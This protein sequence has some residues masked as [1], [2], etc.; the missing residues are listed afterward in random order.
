M[1]AEYPEGRARAAIVFVMGVL[2]PP[3]GARRSSDD[4]HEGCEGVEKGEPS[5]MERFKRLRGL[6]LDIAKKLTWLP[7]L[8]ARLALGYVFIHSGLYK[9]GHLDQITGFFTSL[10]LPAPAFQARFVA[11]TELV[12]GAL[13]LLGAGTRVASLPLAVT[14]V[15]ALVT[16]KK[17][18][19][20]ELHELLLSGEFLNV[21]LLVWLMIAGAGAVSVDRV[22]ARRLE[23]GEAKL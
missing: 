19:I 10:H 12:C 8:L 22:I 21:V 14:M 4:A 16:A 1:W 2:Y 20:H 15:V 17:D 6:V 18:E 23:E 5:Y 3:R 11:G 13:V 7:P 9:F